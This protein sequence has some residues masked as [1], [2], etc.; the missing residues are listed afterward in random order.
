[1]AD[2]LP[3]HNFH[4]ALQDL[5]AIASMPVQ[6]VEQFTHFI[7]DQKIT[8]RWIVQ[9]LQELAQGCSPHEPHHLADFSTE[10]LTKIMQA[11]SQF[12]EIKMPQQNS[13]VDVVRRALLFQS[14]KHLVKDLGGDHA[15]TNKFKPKF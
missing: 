12:A 1:M 13:Y 10:E 14:K 9:A 4:A 11:L 15:Q 2:N 8:Q 3:Q 6:L 7:H 5:L